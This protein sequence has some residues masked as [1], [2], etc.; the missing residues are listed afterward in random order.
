MFAP[1]EVVSKA[2]DLSKALRNSL[3]KHSGDAAEWAAT[4]LE[5]EEQLKLLIEY[6]EAIVNEDIPTS[7]L[8]AASLN[9]KD[10][11]R[12]HVL[13]KFNR[14]PTAQAGTLFSADYQD[15]EGQ[16]LKSMHFLRNRFEEFSY[17]KANV[18]GLVDAIL[19]QFN[20]LHQF[21][22]GHTACKA[23]A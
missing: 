21:E 13:N 19:S 23:L 7:K 5:D 22:I 14:P 4:Q 8:Y 18:S 11:L 6:L 17:A 20:V 9:V 2:K 1:Q 16:R 12:Q 10:G 3:K 15:T